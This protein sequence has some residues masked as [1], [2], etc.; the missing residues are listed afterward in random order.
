MAA[1]VTKPDITEFFAHLTG[2][3]SDIGVTFEEISLNSISEE[4][5]HK[6]IRDL[7]VRNKTG[8]NIIG[9]RLADGSYVINPPPD[10]LIKQDAKLILL[11]SDEQIKGMR[12]LISQL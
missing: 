1:L 7:D 9:L 8:A 10:T 5:K 3:G 11:G 12:L 6:S 4:Y 2:Q